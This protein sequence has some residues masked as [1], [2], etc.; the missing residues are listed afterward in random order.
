MLRGVA[1]GTIVR[2]PA[3]PR[4]RPLR[5]GAAPELDGEV[6]L[7]EPPARLA[8]AVE[9][10]GVVGIVVEIASNASHAP[11]QSARSMAA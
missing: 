5:R 3:G 8:E 9:G 10:V 1:R 4:R 7:V 11:G 6:Q 2:P